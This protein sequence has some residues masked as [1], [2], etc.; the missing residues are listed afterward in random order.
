MTYFASDEDY[1]LLQNQLPNTCEDFR[2][3]APPRHSSPSNCHTV[4]LT[5]EIFDSP[6]T[7]PTAARRA[8]QGF[9]DR[10]YVE[11]SVFSYVLPRKISQRM[12]GSIMGSSSVRW[13]SIRNDRQG[14][15]FK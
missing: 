3:C 5:I 11:T 10:H 6:K 2:F 9:P 12:Q 7:R 8:F 1:F 14:P 15:E 13:A 4:R